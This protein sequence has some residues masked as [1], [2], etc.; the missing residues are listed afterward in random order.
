MIHL[1]ALE[2]DTGKT[3]A[4]AVPPSLAQRKLSDDWCRLDNFEDMYDDVY[5]KLWEAGIAEK[6]DEVVWRDK[7]N[8]IVGTQAEAYG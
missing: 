5:E 4:A 2:Q 7:D 1:I 6:I 3:F 8:N